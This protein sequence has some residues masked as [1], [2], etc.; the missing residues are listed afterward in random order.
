MGGYAISTTHRPAPPA[1]AITLVDVRDNGSDGGLLARPVDPTTLVPL[2]GYAPLS[3]GRSY[4][5][6]LSPDRRTLAVITWASDPTIVGTL[7]LID[8]NTWQDSPQPV[9]INAVAGNIAFGKDGQTLYWAVNDRDA[10]A[11]K[12]QLQR[13]DLTSK[14]LTTAA[15]FPVTFEPRQIYTLSSGNLAIFALPTDL[16]HFSQGVPHIFLV[17]PAG[18]GLL[19]DIPLKGVRAGQYRERRLY[20]G[21]ITWWYESFNPGLAWDLSRGVLYAVHPE[22]NKVTVADLNQGKIIEQA[23]I[24][25]ESLPDTVFLPWQPSPQVPGALGPDV[26]ALSS[27]DGKNLY[28]LGQTFRGGSLAAAKLIALTTDRLPQNTAD[29][30]IR[31]LSLLPDQMRQFGQIEGLIS[32]IALTPDD[33]FLLVIQAEVVSPYGFNIL[34]DRSLDVLDAKTLEPYAHFRLEQFDTLRFNGFSPDGRYAYLRG[35]SATW[36]PGNGWRDPQKVWQVFDLRNFSLTEAQKLVGIEYSALL[37]M[38]P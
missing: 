4:T 24:T 18:K 3:F 7:H 19:A 20:L 21:L 35:D 10:S 25:P 1:S 6:A 34:V 29:Q 16:E 9:Q 26:R 30:I 32:D 38:E 22:K 2:P 28:L 8:L 11:V 17:D 36:V 13:Y 23:T 37:L 15:R 12:A 33:R 27:R 31:S 5:H 14:Q